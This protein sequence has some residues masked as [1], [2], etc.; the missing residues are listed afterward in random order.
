MKIRHYGLLASRQ[1]E[2]RLRQARKLLLSEIA[3][4]PTACMDVKPADARRCPSCG[5]QRLA[6]GEVLSPVVSPFACAVA[7]PPPLE[8]IGDTS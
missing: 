1:R 5:S 2:A 7:S 6:R 8:L 4:S 3:L